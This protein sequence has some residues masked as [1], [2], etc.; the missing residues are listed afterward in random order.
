MNITHVCGIFGIQ[1]KRK[2][3]YGLYMLINQIEIQYAIVLFHILV[4]SILNSMICY[5]DCLLDKEKKEKKNCFVF[6]I[7][8]IRLEQN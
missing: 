4:T 5:F 8:F 2:V 6:N 1:K 3:K 7:S